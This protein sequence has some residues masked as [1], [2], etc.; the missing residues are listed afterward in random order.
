M[1]TGAQEAQRPTPQPDSIDTKAVDSK[2]NTD[3]I[4]GRI[5]NVTSGQKIVIEVDK[6]PD[7]TYNLA[8]PKR[9][10][11]VAE[12][13]AVGDSVRVLESKTKGVEAVD[14]VR[15]VGGDTEQR[16]RSADDTTQKKQ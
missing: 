16:S 15:N 2:K 1:F 14:I 11:R 6:A 3:A 13:L 7:K 9:T 12:G 4:Y 5:K 8:D 10:V